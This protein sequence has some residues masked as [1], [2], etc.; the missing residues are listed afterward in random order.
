M[1]NKSV[2]LQRCARSHRHTPSGKGMRA[3]PRSSGASGAALT[4]PPPGADAGL[5]GAGTHGCR[6]VRRTR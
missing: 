1:A 6:W 2:G 4:W 5:P 3:E